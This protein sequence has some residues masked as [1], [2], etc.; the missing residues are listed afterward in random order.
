MK[1][2]SLKQTEQKLKAK[3]DTES[4]KSPVRVH[5]GSERMQHP[6]IKV[7]TL[8]LCNVIY[9]KSHSVCSEFEWCSSG[10][11]LSLLETNRSWATNRMWTCLFDKSLVAS[12]SSRLVR[13]RRHVLG[14]CVGLSC[15]W[16]EI[17]GNV[18]YMTSQL[19]SLCQESLQLEQPV[20]HPVWEH[21]GGGGEEEEEGW[22]KVNKA[23]RFMLCKE[24]RRRGQRED[25]RC[26]S[27]YT[28][29]WHSP[30][31]PSSPCNYETRALNVS[32]CR[33]RG[34]LVLMKFFMSLMHLDKQRCTSYLQ[35]PGGVSDWVLMRLCVSRPSGLVV[36]SSLLTNA[37][38]N[39]GH[40]CW[41][42]VL[43][44][45]KPAKLVWYKTYLTAK[46][47]DLWNKFS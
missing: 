10:D 3:P 41:C 7:E 40:G 33:A 37:G 8:Y 24:R 28:S 38:K 1:I 16:L 30:F 18:I 9:L 2:P 43:F 15:S 31:P 26:L 27:G 21:R 34:V 4:R 46:N 14:T 32:T 35:A 13:S 22:R 5:Y 11:D 19:K 12:T 42:S 6:K 25:C 47:L 36:Q 44:L 29:A 23:K 45:W 20:Q 39:Y 17:P